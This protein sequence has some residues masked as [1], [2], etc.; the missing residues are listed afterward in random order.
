MDTG[1]SQRE[2]LNCGNDVM[3]KLHF[4]K[5]KDEKLNFEKEKKTRFQEENNTYGSLASFNICQ[6]GAE[7]KNDG[8]HRLYNHGRR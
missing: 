4:I 7:K 2:V 8:K 5:L 1:Y 3:F 6:T